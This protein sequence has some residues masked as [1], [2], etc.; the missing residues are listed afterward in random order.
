MKDMEDQEIGDLLMVATN[1]PREEP[2]E[3]QTISF[4][5]LSRTD[6]AQTLPVADF[7]KKLPISILID[8]DNT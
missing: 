4:Y 8:C 6:A 5:A 3:L 7:I 1:K 2:T